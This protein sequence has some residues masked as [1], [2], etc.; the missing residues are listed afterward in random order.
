MQNIDKISLMFSSA[1]GF[2]ENLHKLIGD[3][4]L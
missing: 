1:F 4:S 3:L 2:R